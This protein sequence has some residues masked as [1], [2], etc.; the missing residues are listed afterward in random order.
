[1]ASRGKGKETYPQAACLPSTLRLDFRLLRAGRE[2]FFPYTSLS[3]SIQMLLLL[4]NCSLLST[5]EKLNDKT[6]CFFS[7]MSQGGQLVTQCLFSTTPRFQSVLNIHLLPVRDLTADSNPIKQ[8][9]KP[10][11]IYLGF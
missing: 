8:E 11:S 9:K 6:F 5:S 4:E 7:F 1:M 2:S 3:D 10:S